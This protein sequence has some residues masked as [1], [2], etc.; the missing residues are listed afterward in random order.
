MN[1]RFENNNGHYIH[2]T[3]YTHQERRVG[4]FIFSGFILIL[5][6]IVVSVK[7][8]HLFEKR[9]TFYINV[10]S[11]EGITQGTVVNALGSEIG[12][13]S[14]LSQYKDGKIRVAIEVYEKERVF[15]KEGAIIVVNRLSNIGS[16]LIEVKSNSKEM[17]ILMAGSTVPVE[18]TVSL[19]DL[20]L[21]MANLIQ[22]VDKNKLLSKL[23][24]IVPKLEQTMINIHNIIDQIASGHGVIGAAVFDEEVENNLKIVVKSG[25]EILSEAQGII[26]IAKQRLVQIEPVL[27][28]AN[29]LVDDM[30]EASRSLPELV[31]E[32]HEI[33]AQVN[34]ALQIINDELKEIPG[35]TTDVKRTL[36]KTDNLLDSVQNTWPLSNSAKEPSQ[37]LLIPAHSN[38]E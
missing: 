33:I 25:T 22:G 11:S 5:F 21:S 28:N 30:R 6:F 23:D 38:H 29:F 10:D 17:P 36:S 27:K 9:V 1:I 19:N 34:T 26:T 32:L 13:V 35:T 8:E 18:E 4:L 12:R 7:N 24:V 14:R 37:Q 15:M 3:S 16:A 20:L 2:Q 31:E